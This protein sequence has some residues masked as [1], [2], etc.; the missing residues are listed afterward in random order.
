MAKPPPR[1]WPQV[2]THAVAL[3]SLAIAVSTLGYT[4]WRN[5]RTEENRNI[6]VAAFEVLKNLGELQFLVN[7]IHYADRADRSEPLRAW[8]HVALVTDLATILPEPVPP[9]AE[10][11]RAVWSAEWQAVATEEA[12]TERVSAAIDAAREAVLTVLRRLR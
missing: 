5:E 4:T 2:R 9:A 11:L 7:R 3:I 8:G 12:A 6:R 10:R 1:L